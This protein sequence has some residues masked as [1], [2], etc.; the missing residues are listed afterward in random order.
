MLEQIS[1]ALG[2]LN[3]AKDIA[4]GIDGLKTGVAIN[5][6]KI[7]LQNL[8]LEAQQGLMAAQ[9]AQ[10]LAGEHIAQLEQQI[11][12]LENWEAEKQRYHLIGIGGRGFAYV[13]KPGMERGEAPVWLCQNC[14]EERHRVALQFTGDVRSVSGGLGMMARWTCGRCKSD[15]MVGRQDSPSGESE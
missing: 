8:I 4:K 10:S 15:V 5:Q 9:V 3:A 1:L 12:Q 6:A 2:S 7:D 14:F 13:H 11:T